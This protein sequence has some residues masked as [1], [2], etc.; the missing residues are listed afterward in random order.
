[1]LW[2][3]PESRSIRTFF[4]T[5]KRFTLQRWE[6]E[7]QLKQ[8]LPHRNVDRY[9]NAIW[10][11]GSYWEVLYKVLYKEKLGDERLRIG[12]VCFTSNPTL[13]LWYLVLS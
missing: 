4:G 6:A 12:L 5:T 2:Y 3:W 13:N 11:T 8:P 9:V 10:A 1:M 7:R